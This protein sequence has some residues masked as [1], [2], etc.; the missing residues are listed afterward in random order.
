MSNMCDDG[1]AF[2]SLEP[3]SLPAKRPR[4]DLD[5]DV[6]ELTVSIL[7]VTTAARR[8]LASNIYENF[9]R[10]S[11]PAKELVVV[12]SGA[13]D[14]SP[15]WAS[16]A[17]KDGRVAYERRSESL[18]V[19]S[20][21]NFG[22]RACTGHVVAQCDDGDAYAETYVERMVGALCLD[23]DRDCQ[24][25]M[26]KD[27][28]QLAREDKRIRV[29]NRM[30]APRLVCLSS[31]AVFSEAAG[32]LAVWDP[33]HRPKGAPDRSLAETWSRE[34]RLE[35][36]WGEGRTYVY[37]RATLETHAYHDVADGGEWPFVSAAA[38]AGCRCAAYRDAPSDPLFVHVLR[39]AATKATV[40]PLRATSALSSLLAPVLG[41][42]GA[43]ALVV[44]D[45]GDDSSACSDAFM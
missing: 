18:S 19:G 39:G 31:F 41:A 15:F 30:Q 20:A 36:W 23:R 6:G 13:A 11:W 5:S 4:A 27:Y 16:I 25:S 22:G 7:T 40:R 37:T 38:A 8:D 3:R 32:H 33:N 12:E 14:V 43:A 21:R 45:D 24:W 34:R 26:S 35:A 42:A 28:D 9:R 29:F 17:Q 2:L 44:A 10:Q 1:S